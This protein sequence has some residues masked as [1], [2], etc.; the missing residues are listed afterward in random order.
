MNDST[1]IQG[2]LK[3]MVAALND[4]YT[5]YLTKEEAKAFQDEISGSFDGVGMEL[6]MKNEKIVVIAPLA[7]SPAEKAGVHA[8]DVVLAINGKSVQSMTLDEAVAAI[9][10]PKN[11]NV[12]LLIQRGSDTPKTI[13]ITRQTIVVEPVNST[14]VTKEG[15]KVADIQITGFNQDTDRLF[16]QAIQ[17]ALNQ[18]VVGFV[19][20]L[21]NN[22]GGYLDQAVK[23]ASAVIP[24][25]PIVSE[26]NRD[27]TRH[28]LSA[29]GNAILSGQK[30][31]VL[32]NNGSASASEI[33]A[34]ALQDTKT[35]TIIGAKSY[36]KGSVQELDQL[37]DGSNLKV[38]VAKW[39]TPAGHSISEVGIQPDI[40]VAAG[41]TTTP[42]LQLEAAFAH[43]LKP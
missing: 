43:L 38:T 10:G 22:P 29:E 18:N 16:R 2:A 21:R 42:D 7:A 11:T 23:V 1:L 12:S 3:G 37:N 30:I 28:T 35:A 26:V 4:P 41:T 5:V 15:K 19:I 25:G 33:V 9:R 34:G 40:T 14:I 6:G 36:G 8:G 17:K 13:A 24:S 39:Y 27:G 32:I 20:D 31:V